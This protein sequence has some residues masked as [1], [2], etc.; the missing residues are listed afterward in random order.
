MTSGRGR[1]FRRGRLPRPGGDRLEP[2]D[3]L[4]RR[5]QVVPLEDYL[6][7]RPERRE[8]VRKLVQDGHLLIGP[9]Y[10]LPEMNVILRATRNSCHRPRL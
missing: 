1:R 6:E 3:G 2:V 4:L 7:L 9:W 10:T 5:G 8:R